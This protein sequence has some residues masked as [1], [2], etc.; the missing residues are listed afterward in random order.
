MRV[1]LLQ[2]VKMGS[3]GGRL[4]LDGGFALH[5]NVRNQLCVRWGGLVLGFR[6][7]LR[8]TWFWD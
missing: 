2:D 6:L 1:L 8:Q 3:H 4:L 7:D 5:H